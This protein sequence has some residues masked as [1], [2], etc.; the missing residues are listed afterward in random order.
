M[1]QYLR[2][3]EQDPGN[4]EAQRAVIEI[5]LQTQD[6]ATAEEH[7]SEAIGLAPRDPMIRALKA[8][9]DYRH[10]ETRA[11]AVASAREV[12]AEAPATLPAQMVLIADRLNAGAPKEALRHG[13]RGARA[14]PRRPG[15][16]PGAARSAR[17]LRRPPP[18]AARS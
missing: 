9:V 16:A 18:A 13:R 6:F 5:A 2:V 15:P 12:V 11:V 14:D 8:T 17:G 4:V 3:A 10:P 1:G 7:A